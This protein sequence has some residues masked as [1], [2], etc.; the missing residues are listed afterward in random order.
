MNIGPETWGGL[1]I[2]IVV[3][4]AWLKLNQRRFDDPLSPFNLLLVGWIGPLLLSRMNLS[5]LEH[6]WSFGVRMSVGYTTLVL[7]ACSYFKRPPRGLGHPTSRL[8]W[9]TSVLTTLKNRKV[10]RLIL[11]SFAISFL[12]YIY[13]EFIRNPIGIPLFALYSDP[14]MIGPA[15]HEWGISRESRSWALYVSIPVYLQSALIYMIG[16]L[17]P[18]G[19]GKWWIVL[20]AVYPIMAILKLNRTNLITTLVVFI[21]VEYYLD[22]FSQSDCRQPQRPRQ[23][24]RRYPYLCTSV[25][26]VIAAVLLG[27]QF[28]QLRN[29]FDSSDAFQEV[30]GTD[31]R[32]Y[33]PVD[34]FLSEIYEY[35][36]L[37]WENF[38]DT[39][40]TYSPAI[41]IGVGFFRPVFSLLGKGQSVDGT[42]DSIGFD[43]SVGSA[44]TY[45]F[46]TNL[47]LELGMLGIIVCPLLYALFVN[48]IY[49]R[50]RREP[51]FLNFCLYLHMPFAWMWLFSSN[52][53]IG[54]HFYLTMAYLCVV[55]R[56]Y[57]DYCIQGAQKPSPLSLAR[58]LQQASRGG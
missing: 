6:P 35:F 18:K 50:F 2:I 39:F 57:Q 14:T 51:N 1:F 28:L 38:A 20:S 30:V 16:R 53:F 32:V 26:A 4:S 54:L 13:N 3:V 8:I 34:G 42:L 33:R 46:I 5:S 15:F 52:A 47:Y 22:K 19:D 58:P 23:F 9:N 55:D 49:A 31:I 17:K 7:V 56:Y 43:P 48:S 10:E 24:V 37:P 11:I 45:P 44:N 36:A 21:A 29:G 12:A 40:E 41:R 27:S 25:L